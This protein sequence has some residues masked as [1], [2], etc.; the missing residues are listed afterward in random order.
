MYKSGCRWRFIGQVH[1]MVIHHHGSKRQRLLRATSS[2]SWT[3]RLWLI[4]VGF[5]RWWRSWWRS[6]TWWQYRTMTTGRPMTD[7][8]AVT[9][10]HLFTHPR[11]PLGGANAYMFYRCLFL[12]FFVVRHAIVHKYKTTVLGN[13][14]TDFH[15]TFTKRYRGKM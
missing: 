10:F 1:V 14:W 3:R 8:S 13:G 5:S 9:F 4:M 15:E 6:Q 2:S 12:F 11:S 7:W